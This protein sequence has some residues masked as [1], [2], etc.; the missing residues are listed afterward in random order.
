MGAALA[1]ESRKLAEDL[2]ALIQ[3]LDP[4]TWRADLEAA[5]RTKVA[6]LRARL[7]G[8]ISQ[9]E[10]GDQLTDALGEV[11]HALD[12]SRDWRGLFERL[13]PAYEAVAVRLRAERIA[14]PQ[15]RQTNYSR[16]LVHVGLGFFALFAI[17]TFSWTFCRIV[18]G[19]LMLFATTA[20]TIRRFSP[21]FN[22]VMMKAFGAIAHPHEHHRIN[23]AS[24]YTAALFILAWTVEP[25]CAAV[26]VIVLGI[27]DPA[28][29]LIGRR[30]GKHKLRAGRSLEGTLTFVVV[31]AVAAFATLTGLYD[32]VAAR[33]LWVALGAGIV[34][35]LAELYSPDVMDDNFT[36]PVATSYAVWLLLVL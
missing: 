8:L 36:I 33:A 10:P 31:G 21:K 32:V 2:H 9:S 17:T 11:A 14:V 22:A 18:I 13:Q 35:A 26:G 1:I 6:A 19:G 12:E 23:S 20:E 15:L 16:S 5:A 4:A 27:A 28:A 25:V 24:W 34:G 3:L 29:A 30:F 7:R